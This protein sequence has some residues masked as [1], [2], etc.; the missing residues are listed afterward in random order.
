MFDANKLPSLR[1]VGVQQLVLSAHLDFI[2]A[3]IT[4]TVTVF[5]QV[6]RYVRLF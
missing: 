3:L 4:V 1:T 6:G 2:F 5:Y